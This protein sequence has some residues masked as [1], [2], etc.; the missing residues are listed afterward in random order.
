MSR[1]FFIVALLLFLLSPALL[2]QTHAKYWVQFKDKS[3]TTF[4]TS[5]PEKFLSP[6]AI[7]KRKRF[8]IPITEQ[9]LPVSATYI[10]Q[11]LA[12]D[13]S[14]ILFTQSK[15]LNGITIY[16]AHDSMLIW[17]QR[18]PFVK[19]CEI[20][21]HMKE[22]EPQI[23]SYYR[24]PNHQTPQYGK[25]PKE[26]ANGALT[27]DYG[28][29]EPQIRINNIHWL[30]RLG[31][32]GE[33]M[34]M[35]IMDGGFLNT[36]QVRH[37]DL[38]HKEN[39]IRDVRN[40]VQP[41]E[42][43]YRSGEHGTNVLSCIASWV[44]GEH[45]GSAPFVTVYLAQTEDG[46][47]ENAVEEDNWVAGLEWADSLG[48]DVLNS[49]LGYIRFD[50]TTYKRTYDNITGKSSR[51]SIAASIA[52]SKGIIVCNSAGNEGNSAWHYI[53][54]PADAENILAVGGVNAEGRRATFSSYG[55][56]ADGRIKPDAVAVG[57]N[58][59]AASRRSKTI[60]IN[61][62]SFSSPLLAGMVTC[63]WQAFPQKSTFEIMDAVRR[64]GNQATQPDSSLGYGITD[65]LKA[66]NL[67]NQPESSYSIDF[68]NYALYDKNAEV[69]IFAP[70]AG[71]A[72]LEF[73]ADSNPQKISS[74]KITLISGKNYYKFSL[75]KLPKKSDYEIYKVKITI[76][77]NS[78]NFILGQEKAIDLKNF[79]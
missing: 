66:Y 79:E 44:P 55:P 19:Y 27:I 12:L 5:E 78:F 52:A 2:S 49:S 50:D 22:A 28:Q 45:V 56:T 20:T 48:C 73:Y 16:A 42:S 59:L 39:R 3:G 43:P 26:Q 54:C 32:R 6:R 75:P 10:S 71:E 18:L 72:L 30:H 25:M 77:G 60:H 64:S 58:A 9:D 63:L 47:S 53:G 15:W 21:H 24:N 65:F 1:N 34:L 23:S 37:F 40:F 67:L 4:S 35:M 46:R 57:R 69:V 61:G 70:E 74:K 8:N 29:A 36:D 33:E 38:L 62:T 7:E 13:T 14:T 76:N 51:A 41:S 31:F 11:V 68:K 17:L